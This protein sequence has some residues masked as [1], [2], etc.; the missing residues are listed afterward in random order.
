MYLVLLCASVEQVDEDVTLVNHIR[1]MFLALKDP[2]ADHAASL[3][4]CNLNNSL[5][6]V[7]IF[8]I[9]IWIHVCPE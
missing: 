3:M 7:K 1:H 5:S 8:F 2:M 9:Q 4:Q 6:L